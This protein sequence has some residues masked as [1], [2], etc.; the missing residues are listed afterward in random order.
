MKRILLLLSGIF[1]LITFHNC[2]KKYN[3]FGEDSIFYYRNGE[4]VTPICRLKYG[5]E[6]L[7]LTHISLKNDTLRVHICGPT[8]IDYM[9]KNFHGKGLYQIT[10][11]NGNMCEAN[12]GYATYHIREDRNTFLRVLEI[13]TIQEHFSAVFEADLI[14]DTNHN[15]RITKGRMDVKFRY[16]TDSN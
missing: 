16:T 10:G 6:H 12:D 13:D 4:P 9:I 1:I 3:E 5:H 8:D 15:L 2:I 7:E 11:T 14:D